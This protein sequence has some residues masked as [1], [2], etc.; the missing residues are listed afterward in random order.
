MWSRFTCT[1]AARAAAALLLALWALSAS[2]AP[3]EKLLMPGKLAQAHAKYE[4]DCAQCHTSFSKSEQAQ[5]CRSCHDKIDADI[6]TRKGFHGLSPAVQGVECRQCHSDHK[7]READIVGLVPA[8]LDHK[9][10][11]FPLKG[12]HLKT[13]CGGCHAQGKPLRDAQGTCI[14]CHRDDDVHKTQMGQKCQDCHGEQSWRKSEFDHDKTDFPLKDKHRDVAC[15]SC[16]PDRKYEKTPKACASCHGLQDRHGGLF[17]DRCA[18]CHDTR[19]WAEARFDHGKTD[20]PLQGRHRSAE[21]HAC[22]SERTRGQQLPTQCY[23]C[24]RG[25]DIHQGRF[26]RQCAQ[27][28]SSDG[29]S[30]K[31]FDH[32]RDTSFAL[33]GAHRKPDCGAC[34]AGGTVSGVRKS[35]KKAAARA[36]IDCHRAD[37]THRGQQGD[38]CDNCHQDKSWREGVRFDHDL[39]RFPLAGLHA[40]V[41]C[42]ECH[43]D[44]A[45]RATAQAC[46]ACHA[47]DDTHK[48]TLGGA[49]ESCHTPAG[50]ARWSF[51]H[52]RQTDYPLESA[53]RE[54]ACGAC[55]RDAVARTSDIELASDCQACHASDDAHR[56]GFG[57][58]CARCHQPT[59]FSDVRV[60][61]QIRDRRSREA[62]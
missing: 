15:A 47:D 16:H 54:A 38:R 18:D 24:H 21:C 19:G 10:T 61:S 5:L 8:L 26:G 43:V 49:C 4:D 11:D 36:C 32:D 17:G 12:A 28:H 1:D 2:A 27:C 25:S 42:A 3:L 30:K 20:F 22:H 37:D 55:H 33:R 50:W 6:R 51:D 58:N 56:G 35:D 7:G 34:H 14:E 59:S 9:L 13:P 39:T 53:H 57:S 44:D 23:D 41:P 52:D 60:S 29:W 46:K 45:Y 62:P 48:G 40:T 31:A